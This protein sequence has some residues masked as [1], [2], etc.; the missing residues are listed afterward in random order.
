MW[1]L[2]S[3]AFEPILLPR[4]LEVWFIELSY[5]ELVGV[6]ARSVLAEHSERTA[7]HLIGNVL[8]AIFDGLD[9]FLPQKSAS[10]PQRL[11]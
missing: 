9:P 2:S 5:L 1:L 7:E 8:R 6:L 3:A 4:S 11:L 10:L